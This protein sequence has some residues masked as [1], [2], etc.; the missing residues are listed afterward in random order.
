M[1]DKNTFT[2]I[3]FAYGNGISP[4]VHIK[5]LYALI[6][7]TPSKIRKCKHQLQ[8]IITNINTHQQKRY[9]FDMDH[10]SFLTFDGLKKS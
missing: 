10:Q 9:C 7:N 3:L 4:D 5:Y 6:L 1:I 8:W 2:L